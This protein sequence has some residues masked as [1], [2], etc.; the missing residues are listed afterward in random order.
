MTDTILAEPSALDSTSVSPR[1]STETDAAE[2]GTLVVRTRAVERIAL[3]AA[4]ATEDVAR[5]SGGI[6]KLSGKDLPTAEVSMIGTT[7]RAAVV[8]AVEWPTPAA[9]V[10][11]R[12]RDAVALGLQT[13][14]NVEVDR[15]DVAVHYITPD[16]VPSGR[17][18]SSGVTSNG[19]TS[20]GPAVSGARAKS[21]DAAR[22]VR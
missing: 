11:E 6:R 20:K 13:F 21:E 19:V 16:E 8:V 18:T 9:A 12:V 22:R 2:R 4:R 1:D 3:A 7:V 15:V 10:A 5:R 17:V 14:G